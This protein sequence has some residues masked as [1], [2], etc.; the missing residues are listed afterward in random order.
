MEIEVLEEKKN[1]FFDRIDLKL[2]I[3]HPNASTPSK[4]EVKKLIASKYDVKEDQV[5][6]D[7]ILGRKGLQEALIKAKLQGVKDET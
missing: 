5:L 7:Y 1:P 4:D 3:K 2:I 6:I